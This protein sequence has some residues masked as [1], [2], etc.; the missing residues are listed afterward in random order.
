MTQ[1]TTRLSQVVAERLDTAAKPDFSPEVLDALRLC[2]IFES[3]RPEEYLTPIDALAGFR[4]TTPREY[5][6][7]PAVMF[8]RL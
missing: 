8:S 7:E 5:A 3:V 6:P 4:S 1:P 2:D